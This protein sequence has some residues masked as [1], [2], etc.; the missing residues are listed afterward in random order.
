MPQTQTDSNGNG[1][2]HKPRFAKTPE[3]LILYTDTD[4]S[5]YPIYILPDMEMVHK[6][7]PEDVERFAIFH[8]KSVSNVS[9][10]EAKQDQLEKFKEQLEKY[11]FSKIINTLSELKLKPA[12]Y[13]VQITYEIY[14]GDYEELLGEFT[15]YTIK[16]VAQ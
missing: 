7:S 8:V 4:Q 16:L 2:V 1:K 12:I 5:N 6:K 11:E 9:K 14:K 10:E 13:I 3:E 15:A